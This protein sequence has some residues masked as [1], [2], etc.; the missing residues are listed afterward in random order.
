MKT[1]SG[2]AECDMRGILPVVSDRRIGIIHCRWAMHE[3]WRTERRFARVTEID[4]GAKIVLEL[5]R[6]AHGEF[7]ERSCGCWRSCM[8]GRS[9]IRR[10][11]IG[12]DNRVR[13]R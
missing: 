4:V 12:A 10:F 1:G 2:Y 5:L 6:E 8:P 11:E 7:I 9:T 3:C 13:L